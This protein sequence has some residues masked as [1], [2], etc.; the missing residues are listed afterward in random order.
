MWIAKFIIKHDCILGN[1][2]EKFKV[3][4]QSVNFSTFKEKGKVVT[5]S[6]HYIS[7]DPKNIQNFIKD[8]KKDKKVI[9]LE[10]KGNIF[11]LLE[12][13]KEKAVAYHNPKI[14]FIKPVLIDEKGYETWEV[15]SWEKEEI[16][17]FIEK[18][19]KNFPYFKL[20]KFNTINLDNVFFPKLLPNLTDKQKRAIELAIKNGYYE[21]PRKTDLR[22]LAK[23]MG[24]SLATFNQHLRA[25]ERKLIPDLLYSFK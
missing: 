18:V 5:S 12:N 19:E 2:C 15:G 6:M 25:A 22:K 14:I 9:K 11:L 20:L 10:S 4:L 7:G 24:L 16:S 21:N 23:T 8:L 13:A 17:K 3:V 1:R